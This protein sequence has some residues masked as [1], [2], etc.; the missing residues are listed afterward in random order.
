M[1][2]AILKSDKTDKGLVTWPKI[3]IY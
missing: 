2:Q 1:L 3:K